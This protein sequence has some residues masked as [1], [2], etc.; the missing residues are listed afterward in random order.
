MGCER[1]SMFPQSESGG[2]SLAFSTAA[3]SA[4]EVSLSQFSISGALPS[5]TSP[6]DLMD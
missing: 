5:H 6:T 4:E 1:G 2:S 3:A